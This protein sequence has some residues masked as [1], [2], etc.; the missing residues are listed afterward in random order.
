MGFYRDH[1]LPKLLD[2]AMKNRMLQPY[3]QRVVGSAEG[4]VLEN[5]FHAPVAQST[6]EPVVSA[7]CSTRLCSGCTESVV[8]AD[9]KLIHFYNKR[10][11][12]SDTPPMLP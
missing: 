7:L 10:R 3:R 1:I 5:P 12:N 6:P 9:L 2:G 4:R 8:N 11:F